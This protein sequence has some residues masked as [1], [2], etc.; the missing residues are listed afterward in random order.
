MMENGIMVSGMGMESMSGLMELDMKVLF[1][2]TFFF[3]FL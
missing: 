2:L 3:N 1:D